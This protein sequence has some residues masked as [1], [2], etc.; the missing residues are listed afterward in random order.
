VKRISHS[1]ISS[2]VVDFRHLS[3]LY[4]T[5][6]LAVPVEVF[7]N[8]NS[9]IITRIAYSTCLV[10]LKPSTPRLSNSLLISAGFLSLQVFSSFSGSPPSNFIMER[11]ID[12][13]DRG[14]RLRCPLSQQALSMRRWISLISRNLASGATERDQQAISSNIRSK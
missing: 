13:G 7:F 5:L 9:T 10:E 1:V 14:A 3:R 8:S 12:I 4:S 2:S 6:S 11:S